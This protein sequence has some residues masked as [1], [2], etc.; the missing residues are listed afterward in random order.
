MRNALTIAGKE[1][2]SYFTSP[3]AYV[4]TVFF[5]GLSGYAFTIIMLANPRAQA[6]YFEGL[7]G[8][9]VLVLLLVTPV[10]TMGLLAQEKASRTIELLMTR[11]VRD[12]EIVI[13]KFMGAAGLILLMLILTLQFPLIIELAGDPDWG[14]ILAGYVGAILAVMSFLALG[15]FASSLTSNQIVAG[16]IALFLLLFFWFIGVASQAVSENLGDLFKH[17]SFVENLQDFSKGIV[18]TK[19]VVYFVSLIGYALF[20]TVRSLENRRAA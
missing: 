15:L 10:L 1:L 17:I 11:P 7:I 8:F 18:D 5:L 3:L 6:D 13:G 20:A 4:V 14:L 9:M 2:R 12:W 19:A 16:V